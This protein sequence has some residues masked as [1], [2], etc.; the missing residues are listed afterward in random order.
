MTPA[1][2]VTKTADRLPEQQSTLAA[3]RTNQLIEGTKK[4]EC[5]RPGH[6]EAHI[7]EGHI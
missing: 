6:A 1:A 3:R 4:N 5:S 2:Q 7:A